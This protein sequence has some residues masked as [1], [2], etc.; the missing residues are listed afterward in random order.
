VLV[1]VELERMWKEAIVLELKI[2]YKHLSALIVENVIN[3]SQDNLCFR[4][5]LKLV[6]TE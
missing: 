1:S 6:Q 2:I 3:F 5:N 4:T